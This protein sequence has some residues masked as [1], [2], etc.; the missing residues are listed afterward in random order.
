MEDSERDG[1]EGGN[2]S[3]AG[4]IRRAEEE[5]A[6]AR[7]RNARAGAGAGGMGLELTN[8]KEL[9]GIS[10]L[11]RRATRLRDSLARESAW[12]REE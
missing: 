12:L 8:A 1:G 2:N 6:K 5:D 10:H 9:S 7:M 11:I 4:G 3:F